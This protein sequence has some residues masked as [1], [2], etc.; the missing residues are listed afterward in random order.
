MVPVGP[1]PGGSL[2]LAGLYVEYRREITEDFRALYSTSLYEVAGPELADLLAS[3]LR[4]PASH[5]HA[6]VAEWKQPIS[7]ESFYVLEL[8]DVL[9]MRFMGEKY[10]PYPR[11]SDKPKKKVGKSPEAAM[12]QLRPH[13]FQD[14]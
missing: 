1:H 14:P 3:L 6:A 7:H 11:P 4:N 9:L 5:F 12:R 2:G 8:I 10:K 13:L